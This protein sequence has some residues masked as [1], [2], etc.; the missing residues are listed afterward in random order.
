MLWSRVL[1]PVLFCGDAERTHYRAMAVLTSAARVP[2]LLPQLKNWTT[3]ADD[4][5]VVEALG[6][7][8]QNPVGLAAGFDKDARWHH[9]LSALGFGF[10]EVGTITDL[11]Q[12]GN[13][14]PRLF[15]LPDDQA[16]LNR[17][18]FNNAGVQIAEQRLAQQPPNVVLGINIGKS[19]LTP[20][21]QAVSSYL[22]T[23][24]RLWRYAHYVA[25]N[26][27]SPNTP[28]LRALQ[29]RQPLLELLQALQEE[30][31]RLAAAVAQPTKPVLVKIAPDL[32]DA[33]VE[34]VVEI[35][36]ATGLAGVIAT[37]TT[38]DRQGLRTPAAVVANMGDGGISGRP[39]HA[40]SCQVVRRLYRRS[41]GQLT[42][43]GVGGI[44]DG[45]DAWRMIGAGASLVQIYTGFVY[46]GPQTVA[47]INRTLVQQMQAHGLSHLSQWVG[48]STDD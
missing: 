18:G 43:V 23:F 9:V 29:D 37:N 28:G 11:A 46:G 41:Q 27:S 20:N 34:D 22:T 14:K 13:P 24:R 33:Q 31:Q 8:F 47:H 4:R 25:I 35:A 45:Q 6:R 12:A 40:R 16:L 42:I 3:V 26:V 15:R 36:M 19:K 32:N 17:L 39:V 38:L 5:L 48:Q 1:R 44:F 7:R 21:Q 10:I 2:G 30:N